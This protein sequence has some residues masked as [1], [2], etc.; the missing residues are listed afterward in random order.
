[1]ENVI[2][3]VLDDVEGLPVVARHIVQHDMSSKY[4]ENVFSDMVMDAFDSGV[5]NK[6]AWE[7]YLLPYEE[8][9][10]FLREKA[11]ET[12]LKTKSG[13]WKLSKV[14][15]NSTYRSNKSVIGN[16]LDKGIRFY[17]D[18]GKL[19]SKGELE[20]ELKGETTTDGTAERV[21]K[22]PYQ[23]CLEAITTI[24]KMAPQCSETEYNDVRRRVHEVYRDE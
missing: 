1:M 16:A 8:M 19:K 12:G 21:R 15:H 6:K 5:D 13:K 17:S 4:S 10:L 14:S 2:L 11:G 22:T 20:R 24:I 18:E 7:N 9:V 23:R 3:T